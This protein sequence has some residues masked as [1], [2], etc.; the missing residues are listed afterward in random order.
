MNIAMF[1]ETLSLNNG[2]SRIALC[3][4]EEYVKR[5]H[6]VHIYA[7]VNRLPDSGRK[8]FPDPK[9]KFHWL[10]SLRGSWRTW[11]MPMGALIP[12]ARRYFPVNRHDIIVSHALT[13]KQ[14]II[15]M[16]NDPQKIEEEKLAGV[17]FSVVVPRLKSARR[18][19]R[20]AIENFRFSPINFR[21]IVAH[22]QR[23]AQEI[24]SAFN[25]EEK[26][27]NV[28]PHGVDS[29]Y[30][31]PTA[32]AGQGIGLRRAL[33]ISL[34]EVVF[35]YIGDSW[36]GL[37]F[38]IRGLARLPEKAPKVLLAAG[39]FSKKVFAKFAHEHRVR[40]IYDQTWDDARALYSVA[41]VL[42]NPTPLDTFFLAGLEAM[43]MR[44]PVVTTKYAGL[45]ELLT[46]KQN[47]F[48]LE[49]VS[50]P[51]PIAEA[52]LELLEPDVRFRMAENARQFA[53][54]RSW[55][56]CALKHLRQYDQSQR[57]PRTSIVST[58]ASATAR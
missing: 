24:C 57:T 46:H 25:I 54:T 56:D 53:L 7:C 45:S 30:F 18:K 11:S 17:P 9:I 23:S 27:A 32:S 34:D 55:E 58:N 3:L 37:E 40:F 29:S 28:I 41:D 39:P 49:S 1:V 43:S 51:A 6:E 33:G 31:S 5:G 38:A 20:A 21:S 2:V 15:Q 4:S 36:K 42:L 8:L 48:I 47:S 19:V 10:P 26:R 16:H 14:D 12:V 50:D 52:C 22:S 35:L 44:V 13:F